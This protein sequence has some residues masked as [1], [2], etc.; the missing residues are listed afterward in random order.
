MKMDN[1]LDT[2]IIIGYAQNEEKFLSFV[3]DKLESFIVCYFVLDRDIS[4]LIKRMKIII[5]EV[6]NKLKDKNYEIQTKDLYKQDI[7]RI[8][9]F[10][11]LKETQ[12]R[13]SVEFIDFLDNFQSIFEF[14]IEFFIQKLIDKKVMPIK[15]IDFELKS[16]LFTYTKNHSDANILASGIQHHQ[17]NKLILITSDK[18]DWTK[19]NLEW[20]IPESS[21]LRK[22]YSKI[23]QIKYV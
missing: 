16:N 9:K 18:Q 22:K 7:I 2:S 19:E 10:L 17:E 12:N 14:R 6:K 4:S 13:S 23:P 20:A 11:S 8:Q 1:F 15:E 3:K 5:N 21:N